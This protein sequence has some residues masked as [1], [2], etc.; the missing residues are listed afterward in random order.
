MTSATCCLCEVRAYLPLGQEL[1]GASAVLDRLVDHLQNRVIIFVVCTVDAP[2]QHWPCQHV[3]LLI[4]QLVLILPD[5]LLLPPSPMCCSQVLS[6]IEQLRN[7]WA[8]AKQIIKQQRK[9]IKAQGLQLQLA[10]ANITHPLAPQVT[11]AR[12]Q[13]QAPQQQQQPE[14]I[15]AS[16][17]AAGGLGGAAAACSWPSG[18]AASPFPIT[19]WLLMQAQHQQQ[20]QHLHV[21]GAAQHL[22]TTVA[23][24]SS[25]PEVTAHAGG[26]SL[27]Q[28]C[29][30]LHALA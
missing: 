28:Q 6:E 25:C 5:Q 8:Q 10:E 27:G 14:G 9:T 30:D 15:G 18:C 26:C 7:G 19:N 20:G 22:H 29:R 23:G 1:S 3:A 24:A 17:S 16:C 21:P 12:H 13:H 2:L 4:I 11:Q